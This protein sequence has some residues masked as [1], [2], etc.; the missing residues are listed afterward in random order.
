[1]SAIPDGRGAGLDWVWIMHPDTHANLLVDKVEWLPKEAGKWIGKRWRV[2]EKACLNSELRSRHRGAAI[3]RCHTWNLERYLYINLLLL[4]FLGSSLMVYCKVNLFSVDMT[5]ALGPVDY[6]FRVLAS[7]IEILDKS[8]IKKNKSP[9]IWISQ[10]MVRHG[11]KEVIGYCLSAVF[12]LTL[13]LELLLYRFRLYH[14]HL[15]A[16]QRASTNSDTEPLLRSQ[17]SSVI[18]GVD[19]ALDTTER[20]EISKRSLFLVRAIAL[21]CICS[22]SVGVH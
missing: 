13:R 12:T 15:M 14:N 22:L 7:R 2:N 21:L 11:D 17:E 16:Q 8:W 5:S 19:W 18:D 6:V 10:D 9:D 4:C 20:S 1:M 3:N